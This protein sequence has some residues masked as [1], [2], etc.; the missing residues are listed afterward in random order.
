MNRLMTSIL[1][2]AAAAALSLASVSAASA[3]DHWHHYHNNDGWVAGAAGLATGLIVGSA[4]ASQ[5]TYVEPAPYYVE[6]DYPPPP[7]RYYRAP[8]YVAPREAYYAPPP[9]YALRP[10]SPEWQRYCYDR[11]R[12]FDGRTGTY[13]GYDGMRHFCTAG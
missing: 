8:V 6:P 2:P 11:Y 1:I 5:P 4:I 3:D 10:W 9:A 7:P 12:T 13:V